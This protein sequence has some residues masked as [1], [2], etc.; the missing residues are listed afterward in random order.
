MMIYEQN[1]KLGCLTRIIIFKELQLQLRKCYKLLFIYISTAWLRARI[2]IIVKS[3]FLK[4]VISNSWVHNYINNIAHN[5]SLRIALTEKILPTIPDMQTYINL[6]TQKSL[7]N[8]IWGSC[9]THFF[10]IECTDR[11]G[12]PTSACSGYITSSVLNL[13]INQ[14]DTSK[15]CQSEDYTLKVMFDGLIVVREYNFTISYYSENVPLFTHTSLSYLIN[16]GYNSF[17][18]NVSDIN[19]NTCKFK[20]LF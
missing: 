14:T 12:Q 5:I 11:L 18:G 13:V 1:L 20:L 6:E 15:A 9:T 19:G 10:S 4:I 3:R 8:F 16:L 2:A 7:F 17:I